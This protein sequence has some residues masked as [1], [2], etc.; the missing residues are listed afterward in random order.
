M[1]RGRAEGERA[2]LARQL[3]RRFGRLPPAAAERLRRAPETDLET[4]ADNVLDAQT[5]D[6]VFGSSP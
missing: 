3:E 1:A 5:L 4:W 2:M 6:D